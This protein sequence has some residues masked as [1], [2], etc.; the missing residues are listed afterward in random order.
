MIPDSP[1]IL[2]TRSVGEVREA[3]TQIEEPAFDAISEETRPGRRILPEKVDPAGSACP[4]SVDRVVPSDIL[5]EQEEPLAVER[6]RKWIPP[7]R[8]TPR[9]PARAHPIAEKSDSGNERPAEEAG[10][11]PGRGGRELIPAPHPE[12]KV[13]VMRSGTSPR[14]G[15]T[16]RR[17][18]RTR[19]GSAGLPCGPDQPCIRR[20]PAT[21]KMQVVGRGD[22]RREGDAVDREATGTSA[23]DER[24]GSQPAPSYRRTGASPPFASSPGRRLISPSRTASLCSERG[25]PEVRDLV[26]PCDSS[27]PEAPSRRLF[28]PYLLIPLRVVRPRQI[29]RT[30][31]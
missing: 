19:S 7:L 12:V 27:H 23:R 11:R 9:T 17:S 21:R 10:R 8:D 30:L 1:Q 14:I 31:P 24:P 5:G 26:G 6:R 20:K 25:L 15:R 18:L 4:R 28:A 2:T 3:I 29:R 13:G 22:Q 16:P